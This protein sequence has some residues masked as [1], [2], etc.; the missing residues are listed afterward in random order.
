MPP[1]QHTHIHTHTYSLQLSQ[2]SPTFS[3]DTSEH[4]LWCNTFRKAVELCSHAFPSTPMMDRDSSLAGSGTTPNTDKLYRLFQQILKIQNKEHQILFK[5]CH[6]RIL[7]L[8]VCVRERERERE[9]ERGEEREGGEREEAKR[10]RQKQTDSDK[11]TTLLVN[12]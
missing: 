1:P 10:E 3:L 9:R 2:S 6:V 12:V 11:A 4:Q 5:E 8:C 7:Q